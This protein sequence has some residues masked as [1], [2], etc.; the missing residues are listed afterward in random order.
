MSFLH[1]H[2]QDSSLEVSDIMLTKA[3]KNCIE[4]EIKTISDSE[5]II[6]SVQITASVV[7]IARGQSVQLVAT[8]KYDDGSSS[9]VTSVVTWLLVEGDN[10]IVSSAGLLVGV[11]TGETSVMAKINGITSNLLRV[12]V[13][14]AVII[15]IDVNPVLSSSPVILMKGQSQLFSAYATYSD[16]TYSRIDR[17]ATWISGD[18]N[19]AKI[20]SAG[21]LV[22]VGVG[23]TTLVAELNGISSN[24]VRVNISQV[25][26][27]KID[28]YPVFVTS[29]VKIMKGQTQQFSAYAT[30]TDGSYTSVEC[31]STWESGNTN[32][33]KVTE[34]GLLLGINAG[35][36]T[37]TV[38]QGGIS[39]NTVQVSVLE[40]VI[41]AID[42]QPVHGHLGF[43]LA[44][45]QTQFFFAFARYSDGTCMKLGSSVVWSIADTNI[46]KVASAGSIVGVNVGKTTLKAYKDGIISNT[47][48]VNVDNKYLQL[49]Y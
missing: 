17:A 27:V 33:A 6:T 16:G 29:P 46:A 36:T 32:I 47:I 26:I 38:S 45:G 37:V 34:A 18:T 19:I 39:S 15:A 41:I 9:I 2:Y 30:Y 12:N 49:V 1:P 24:P 5:A 3:N 14:E 21:S 8:A 13:S 48:I 7:N 40:P 11:K 20:V 31:L 4:N 44:K 28:L 23:E 22:G 43:K 35:E 10:V 25:K 42:I